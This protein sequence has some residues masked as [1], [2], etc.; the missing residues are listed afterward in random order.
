MTNQEI[1]EHLQQQLTLTHQHPSSP[2]ILQDALNKYIR[3]ELAWSQPGQQILAM[4][5]ER[6]AREIMM[7]LGT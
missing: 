4:R 2:R 1:I 6:E 7:E 5:L 3:A